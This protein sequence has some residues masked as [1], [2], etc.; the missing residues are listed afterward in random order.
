MALFGMTGFVLGT[1]ASIHQSTYIDAGCQTR[2]FMLGIQQMTESAADGVL[3][4]TGENEAETYT[5]E[6]WSD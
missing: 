2:C 3:F 6:F 5:L 1:A 4:L